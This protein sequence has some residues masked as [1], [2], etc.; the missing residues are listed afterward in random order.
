MVFKWHAICHTTATQFH[1]R[2]WSAAWCRQ[3][4]GS[5]SSIHCASKD[6][7]GLYP[8]VGMWFWSNVIGSL[9]QLYEKKIEGR[10][11]LF[12]WWSSIMAIFVRESKA[13][14]SWQSLLNAVMSSH[15]VGPK[16]IRRL[17]TLYDVLNL[18][19][20][21]FLMISGYFSK[22]HICPNSLLLLIPE[23]R[24]RLEWLDVLMVTACKI[25]QNC[26]GRNFDWPWTHG[27][28]HQCSQFV[29][30]GF[31]CG[32]RMSYKCFLKP[33]ILAQG[34]CLQVELLC[35]N[36]HKTIWVCV[37]VGVCR[38]QKL[39]CTHTLSS[40]AAV[41]S[42]GLRWIAISNGSKILMY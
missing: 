26:P 27:K 23:H 11:L 38:P 24:Q 36:L 19:N 22:C 25:C 12:R 14:M 10:M 17:K 7:H 30:N 1:V 20:W 32:L 40:A 41:F 31:H 37:C 4:L 39:S 16:K 5:V 18:W 21:Q 33:I 8:S 3:V 34:V 28:I 35:V 2:S 42:Y 15:S 6:T 13:T 9:L 29:E